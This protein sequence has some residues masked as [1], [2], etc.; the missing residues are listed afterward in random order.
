[1]SINYINSQ[2]YLSYDIHNLILLVFSYQNL[3]KKC[4][5]ISGYHLIKNLDSNR[6]EKYFHF[7]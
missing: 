7:V 2:I 6:L 4:N 3:I 5:K 1:M